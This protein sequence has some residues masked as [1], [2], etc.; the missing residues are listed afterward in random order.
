MLQ[1][2][3]GSLGTW[4]DFLSRSLSTLPMHTGIQ[5]LTEMLKWESEKILFFL[6]VLTL[7]SPWAAF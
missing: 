3:N 4:T 5:V 1:D 2:K 6:A 7:I